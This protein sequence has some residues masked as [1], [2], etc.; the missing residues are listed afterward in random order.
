MR[1]ISTILVLVGLPLTA[2]AQSV[3]EIAQE[4]RTAVQEINSIASNVDALAQQ[5]QGSGSE[6]LIEC[7]SAKQ[8]AIS[9]LQDVAGS[10]LGTIQATNPNNVAKAAGELRKINLIANKV[11]QFG[12]EA[13]KCSAGGSGGGSNGNGSGQ[14]AGGNSEVTVDE[15]GVNSTIS[16]GGSVEGETNYSFNSTSSSASSDESMTN[17]EGAS[18]AG[19]VE[20]VIVEQ[21]DV[22][23]F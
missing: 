6:A 22:S 10:S 23:P 7:V 9:G 4:A 8:G 13:S 14:G 1:R 21:E 12:D 19:T 3:P 15:S 18:P 17:A 11:R 20:E 16:E 2:F 5:A